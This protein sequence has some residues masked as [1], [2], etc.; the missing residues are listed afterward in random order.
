V[1]VESPAKARREKPLILLV[2]DCEDNRDMYAAFLTRRGF[3]IAEAVDGQQAIE[4]STTLRPDLVVM[5]LSLPDM[6]GTQAIRALR[7]D[8]RTKDLPI[9]VVSGAV[10][11]GEVSGLGWDAFIAKPCP[12]DLLVA[13]IRRLI[14]AA[15]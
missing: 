8:D 9:I 12:P 3:E 2:E 14:T 1:R 5:D 7:A 6:D 4:R 11:D 15:G 13:E 10:Q